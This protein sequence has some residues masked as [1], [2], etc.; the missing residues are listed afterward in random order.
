MDG[1]SVRSESLRFA[2]EHTTLYQL[3]GGLVDV[4]PDPT[5]GFHAGLT[6]GF[7]SASILVAGSSDDEEDNDSGFG[8]GLGAGY[9]FWVGTQWCLGA[10]LELAD[11]SA[12]DN[13]GDHEAFFSLI[14]SSLLYH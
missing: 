1:R 4:Y 11:L 9:D 5:R 8:I 2:E 7:A 6:V 10:S 13:F 12:E 14:V 3:I